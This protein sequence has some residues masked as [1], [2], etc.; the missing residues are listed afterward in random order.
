MADLVA[1]PGYEERQHQDNDETTGD[2]SLQILITPPHG[3]TAFQVGYLGAQDDHASI[4]GEVQIKGGAN[5]TWDRVWVQ[6]P[7]SG[8]GYN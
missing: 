1:P 3:A 7:L 4:E 8:G 6:L 2:L 5:T